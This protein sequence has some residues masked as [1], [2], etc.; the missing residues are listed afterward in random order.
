MSQLFKKEKEIVE[1][2][3]QKNTN[4]PYLIMR[5]KISIWMCH[6]L[7]VIIPLVSFLAFVNEGPPKLYHILVLLGL[8][9]TSIAIYIHCKTLL[10]IIKKNSMK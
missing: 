3:K 10:R 2:L 8:I 1:K 6:G 7:W 5:M 4:I 9:C